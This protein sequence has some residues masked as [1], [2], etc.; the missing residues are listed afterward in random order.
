ME[1][2]EEAEIFEWK[3]KEKKKKKKPSSSLEMRC[4]V[5]RRQFSLYHSSAHQ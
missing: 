2:G 1:G 4:S 5:S 3:T